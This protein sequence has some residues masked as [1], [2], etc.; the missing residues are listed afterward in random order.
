MIY[1]WTLE[2]VL[3]MPAMDFFVMLREGRVLNTKRTYSF[4]HELTYVTMIPSLTQESVQAIRNMF[5]SFTVTP[6]E[7]LA[8]Q[9]IVAQ[10]KLDAEKLK[11]EMG[12]G[13]L[14][15]DAA[16]YAVMNVFAIKR[17]A[18]YGK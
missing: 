11:A 6:E 4:L 1:H 15:G 3:C 14:E 13:P 5:K 16:K 18:E 12:Y 9:D 2:S 17:K 10:A 8:N 7:E